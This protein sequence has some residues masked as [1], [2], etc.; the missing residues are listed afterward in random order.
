MLKLYGFAVSNYFNMVK[1]AADLKKIDYQEVITY[2]N[3]TPE[4]LAISPTGKVPALE[5][6][7]GV[8][9][10]T[11]VI[12]EYLDDNYSGI[13]L[14]PED[15]FQ[16]AKTKELIKMLE[17]Y[18]ELPARRCM[19]E[20]FWGVPGEDITKKEVKRA[21]LN[22]MQSLSRV[23]SFSPY[24]AGDQFTAADIFFLYSA[25]IALPIATKLFDIDLLAEVPGA[26]ELLAKLN[27]MPE[28]KVIAQARVEAMPAFNAYLQKAFQ[29]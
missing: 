13:K 29:K 9:I 18:M 25:D 3:Q 26:K 20:A 6:E 24:I 17:L 4:Y 10:E 28:A 27:D 2:P 7:H 23:A 11:N 16:K 21:L 8:L 22:G 1:L 15:P 5:T 14:Y 12:L 19:A